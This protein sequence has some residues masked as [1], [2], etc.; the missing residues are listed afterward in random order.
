MTVVH[1]NPAGVPRNPAFSQAVSVQGP[2]RTIYVG[3][4]NGVVADGSI[5]SDDIGAQT[6]RAL[7][8]LETVLAAAGAALENVVTWSISIVEGQDVAEAFAAFQRAWGDR[9]DPPAISLSIV[10]GLANPRFL[11]EIGATAVR[12]AD[13]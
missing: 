5:V 9:L 6:A 13:E 11:V 10:T 3:G 8:N 12:G 1:H 2:S 4:Q 7:E